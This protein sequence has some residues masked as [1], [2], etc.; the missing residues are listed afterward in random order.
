MI[1]KFWVAYLGKTEDVVNEEE[2]ILS[3]SISK[4]LS[5]SEAGQTDPGTCTRGLIHLTIDKGTL[6]LTLENRHV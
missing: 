6:A 1:S 3:F 2:D 4:M 5:Y